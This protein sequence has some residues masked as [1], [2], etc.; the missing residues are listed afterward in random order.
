MLLKFLHSEKAGMTYSHILVKK[1]FHLL[2]GLPFLIKYKTCAFHDDGQFT[3]V[4]FR[5]VEDKPSCGGWW[6]VDYKVTSTIMNGGTF[7]FA[8]TAKESIA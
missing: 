1:P 7:I 4:L 3:C 6:I 8:V 2:D 5:G